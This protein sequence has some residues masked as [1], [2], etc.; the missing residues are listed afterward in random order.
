MLSIYWSN[1]IYSVVKF[2]SP[3]LV[4]S[5][6]ALAKNGSFGFAEGWALSV[7]KN[8]MCHLCGRLSFYN[9]A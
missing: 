6:G 2:F 4:F 8:Q 5:V 1:V 9:E 3:K 7:G